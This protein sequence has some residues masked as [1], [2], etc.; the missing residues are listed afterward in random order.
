MEVLQKSGN[1][2]SSSDSIV[3]AGYAGLVQLLGGLVAD[4]GVSAGGHAGP[5]LDFVVHGVPEVYVEEL[6]V[7][8]DALVVGPLV[9]DATGCQLHGSLVWHFLQ[10]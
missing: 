6:G 8:A 3:M 2:G 4:P 5:G 10:L 7:Q 9:Q 1:G